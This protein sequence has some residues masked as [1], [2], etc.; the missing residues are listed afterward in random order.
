M[1]LRPFQGGL[2]V[3]LGC[4]GL[5]F[6]RTGASGPG[7]MRGETLVVESA[8]KCQEGAGYVLLRRRC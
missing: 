2:R 6:A 5:C 1:F 7:K 4:P 8:C 3:M